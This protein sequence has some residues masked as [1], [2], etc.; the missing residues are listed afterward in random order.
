MPIFHQS[1]GIAP[2]MEV[3]TN[4]TDERRIEARRPKRSA[5]APQTNDPTAVP[6]S[7]ENGS[8][9]TVARSTP[10]S[11]RIP[12]V[13]NPRLAGFMTSMTRATA[14]TAINLQW[15]WVKAASSGGARN[16]S[17]AGAAGVFWSR[18]QG[19]AANPPPQNPPPQ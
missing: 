12:G 18:P 6:M 2:Q 5:S 7:A 9:A 16:S 14:S 4:I 11:A 8:S 19:G 17:A 10:Y 13:T 1:E 15:A 3:P